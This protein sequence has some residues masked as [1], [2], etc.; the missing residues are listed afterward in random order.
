MKREYENN[1][2]FMKNIA[3]VM[4]PKLPYH[5][6]E[7]AISV[8]EAA[9]MLAKT[10]GLDEKEIYLLGTAGLGHDLSYNPNRTDNEENTARELVEILP[11]I[12]YDV[13][14][15]IDIA[16]MIPSTKM[17]QNPTNLLEQILCDSDLYNLGGDEF[18][19]W[20]EKLRKEWNKPLNEEWYV[21]QIEFLENHKYHTE[22]AREMR[23]FGKKKNIYWLKDKIDSLR[24]RIV[25]DEEDLYELA[26]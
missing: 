18:F 10:H 12:G 16:R 25:E 21:S 15:A 8:Y 23:D 1:I 14:D 7:H 6:Y 2:R 9:I 5:N 19:R 24:G 20:S 13:R 22:I 26:I 17:P 3:K 4:M 11:L